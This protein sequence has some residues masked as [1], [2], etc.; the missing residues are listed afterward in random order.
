M[1][2]LLSFWLFSPVRKYALLLWGVASSQDLLSLSL[3]TLLSFTTPCKKSFISVLLN[4][5]NMVGNAG[6]FMF[7]DHLV[8]PYN[9]E[10]SAVWL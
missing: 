1:Q 4:I 9:L 2:V 3:E 8:V 10:S 5:R 7:Y 6:L